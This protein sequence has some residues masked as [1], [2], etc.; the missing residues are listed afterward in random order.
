MR[1]YPECYTCMLRQALAAGRQ[2]GAPEP[3]QHQIVQQVLTILQR[4]DPS[5]SPSEI[6]H[7]TNRAVRE[8]TGVLDP[9]LAFKTACTQRALQMVP[10]LTR[11]LAEAADPLEIAVRLAIAGNIIDAVH[12]Y[13]HDLEATVEKTLSQPLAGNGVDTLREALGRAS[14]VLYLA[15]NAGETVFDRLLIERLG[16]SVIYAVKGSPILNDATFA[17]ALAAGVDRVAQIV[18]TGA[19]GPGTALRFCT[20]EFRRLYDAADLIV[21]K[22]QANYETSDDLDGRLFFML[23]IKCAV[24]G[25][26]LGFPFGSVVLQGGD[27]ASPAAVE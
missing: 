1:C 13:D 4:S 3:Q 23:Q 27:R 8:V 10:R 16:K 24:L 22:G 15:D 14:R 25:R 26:H 17:D 11:L 7:Y 6:A 21:V 19:D 5:E 12:T 2:A 18:S 9:Y 20:D